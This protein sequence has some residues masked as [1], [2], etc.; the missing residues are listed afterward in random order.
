MLASLCTALVIFREV[1]MALFLSETTNRVLSVSIWNLRKGGNMGIAAAGAMVMVAGMG[2][3]M[4][5]ALRLLEGSVVGQQ[6]SGMSPV[7][8]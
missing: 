7:R 3:L 6:R 5:L 8:G 4:L 1:T 2:V